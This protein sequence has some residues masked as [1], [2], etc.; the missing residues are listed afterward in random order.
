MDNENSKTPEYD[1]KSVDMCLE[2]SK[3]EYEYSFRRAEK[4]DN[5]VYVLL[6]VCGFILVMLLNALSRIGEI[7][8][9][10]PLGNKWVMAYD[11]LSVMCVIGLSAVLARLIYAMSGLNIKRHDS[12]VILEQALMSKNPL[13]VARFTIIQYEMIRAYN[14]SSIDRRYASLNKSVKM[15][16]A[17]AVMLLTLII[18]SGFAAQTGN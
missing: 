12:N 16:I 5:K 2:I 14:N 13:T 10:S 8:V 1:S 15:L 9:L 6:T 4:F 17:V 18:V 3:L 11:V 7:D